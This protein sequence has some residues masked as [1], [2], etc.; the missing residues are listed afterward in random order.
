MELHKSK[1][2]SLKSH[3]L[4]NERWLQTQIVADPSLLGLGD[5]VVRNQERA[6]PKGGRLDLLLEDSESDTR[7]EIELQLGT[8]DESHIVRTLEYWD[9]ERRRY[10][11]YDHVAVI[12][13]EEITSR[14]FNVIGLFNGFIPLIAIQLAA[15]EVNGHLT[16][17]FTRVLDLQT[18][19]T[20]EEDNPS[21]STDRHYW[22]TKASK[23][24][25]AVVDNLVGLVLSLIHI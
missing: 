19:G 24:T 22:E 2:V 15:L 6:Q 9:L 14:F 21:L 18:L 12:V 1:I 23:Q 20:E 11:Q 25:L 10:P 13:A 7:Y 16:L 3:P 5:L 8:V 4:L 17:H